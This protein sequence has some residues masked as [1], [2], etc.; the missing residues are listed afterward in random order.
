MKTKLLSIDDPKAL[1]NVGEVL[2]AGGLVVFPT[3]TVYGLGALASKSESVERIFQV[4]ARS[5]KK[6]LPVLIAGVEQLPLVVLEVSEMAHVLAE[7]FWPG[8]LTIVLLRKPDLFPEIGDENTVGIRVPDHDFTRRMLAEVGPMAATSANRSGG[9]NPLTAED[10][11]A[12]LW[13]SFELLIDGGPTH[14]TSPSTVVDCSGEAPI[15][16][17]EGPISIDQI[18]AA[19]L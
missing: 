12:D 6:A 16:L 7:E 5:R 4:K 8:P 19:L 11:L 14:G 1:A 18:R 17:R 10:V 9:R 3:D 13:G 15:I 2:R